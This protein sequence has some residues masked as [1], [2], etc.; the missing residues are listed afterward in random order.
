MSV[1]LQ[2]NASVQ[3]ILAGKNTFLRI[4]EEQLHRPCKH[5]N[6]R[7]EDCYGR[8]QDYLYMRVAS[9]DKRN[10]VWAKWPMIP[11]KTR[12]L[13]DLPAGA[14]IKRVTAT[15]TRVGPDA[16]WTAEFTIEMPV[17]PR[18][19]AA[20]EGDTVAIDLG[21]TAMNNAMRVATWCDEHGNSGHV[22]LDKGDDEHRG[23]LARFQKVDDIKSIRDTAFN[24]ARDT[25][26]AWLRTL[27][28]LPDW[29]LRATV[30]RDDRTPSK[31]Q[32]LAYLS[33]WR[34]SARLARLTRTW[35][36]NRF[37]GDASAFGREPT[38]A[39]AKARVRGTGLVGWQF[40]DKHLWRWQSHQAR[41][42]L[43]QRREIY[44][45]FSIEMAE[46][47]SHIVVS[48]TNY[49]S[50]ARRAP[51]EAERGDNETAKRNRMIAASG[52]LRLCIEQASAK[53]GT[54]VERS[55]VPAATCPSCD[56]IDKARVDVDRH[57]YTCVGC[58]AGDRDVAQCLSMLRAAGKAKE[59]DVIVARGRAVGKALRSA[60]VSTA[61]A[62]PTAAG[63]P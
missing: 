1:Q 60:R 30:K 45:Q 7:A 51:D 8:T 53:R 28:V 4:V 39:E 24:A 17:A 33:E 29:I 37:D 59:V 57:E 31:A 3:D 2:G 32:A 36:E 19:S 27:A 34:S 63:A 15:A 18:P 9:D 38:M 13:K 12:R 25:L 47:Y 43:H 6:H 58:Y 50:T 42:V 21:W 46:K 52:A 35:S 49:A 26:V 41:R 14:D 61:H 11:N 54:T 16:R 48:G 20:P 56:T 44:R 62:Q 5:V 40:Q 22:T 23:L 10:A 55:H